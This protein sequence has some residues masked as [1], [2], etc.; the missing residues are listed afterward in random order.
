LVKIVRAGG[1]TSSEQWKAALIGER[2]NLQGRKH[3]TN[4]TKLRQVLDSSSGLGGRPRGLLP[5]LGGLLA[6]A[7]AA[8][9]L[10]SLLLL[11]RI[12]P[13]L[14]GLLQCGQLWVVVKLPALLHGRL[15]YQ[16]NLARIS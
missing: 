9:V 5:G 16:L 12:L 6:L 2:G 10:A 14:I 8:R 1:K 4:K 15:L 13:I 11:P 3:D 7:L